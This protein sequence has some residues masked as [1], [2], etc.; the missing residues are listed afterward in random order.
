MARRL[1]W[2]DGLEDA[3]EPDELSPLPC[4]ILRVQPVDGNLR[5][6]R[7]RVVTRAVFIRQTLGLDLHMQRLGGLEAHLAHVELLDDVEH[8]QRRE[9]LGVRT[10]TVDVHAAVVGHQRLHP[11]RVVLAEVFGR[12]PAADALEVGVY[13]P[14]DR[15][16]V[17]GVAAAFGDHSIGA[18]QVGV[19]EDVVL[20]RCSA[21]GFV[22]VNGVGCLLDAGAR[23]KKGRHV[24]L[25]VVADDLRDRGAGLAVVD[26]RLEEFGP[27]EFAVALVQ[28]PPAVERARRGDRNGAQVR[29][30]AILCAG[31]GGC[32]RQ[33]LWRA[34]RAG[35]A[36]NLGGL[37]VP[38]QGIAVAAKARADGLDEAEHYVCGD[39]S[40]HGRPAP[41]E[42]LDGSLRCERMGSPRSARTSE[43][44]G[45]RRK[46]RTRRPVACMDVGPKKDLFSGCLEFGKRCDGGRGSFN[47][48]W[49][50]CPL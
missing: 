40:I 33:R 45:A 2:I 22:G 29:Q 42:H 8:L 19:A 36:H 11:F 31:T 17:E 38:E 41:L 43:R 44:C 23:A 32:E 21:G 30:N 14:G 48:G 6:M 1:A 5:K 9:T 34:A 20:V 3:V 46:A 18:G 35:H 47:A 13:G 16:V 25:D 12:Q 50:A 15:A 26:S 7:V 28:R 49:S 24:A 27:L 37:R 10:H 4:V 39:R